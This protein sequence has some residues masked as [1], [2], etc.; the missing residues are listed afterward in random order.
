M[1]FVLDSFLLLFDEVRQQ[2]FFS[3]NFLI[4]FSLILECTNPEP[5]HPHRI[6]VYLLEIEV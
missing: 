5:V 1:P 4:L 6:V 2:V 3:M